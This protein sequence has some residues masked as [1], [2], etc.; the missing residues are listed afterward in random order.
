MV[1][2]S[3]TLVNSRKKTRMYQAGFF[4]MGMLLASG[5]THGVL[6]LAL[7]Q[8]NFK[9]SKPGGDFFYIVIR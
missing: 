8:F 6:L 7:F 1:M 9:F 5:A 3:S 4:I 2:G